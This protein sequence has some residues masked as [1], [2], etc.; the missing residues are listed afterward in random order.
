MRALIVAVVS[1]SSAIAIAAPPKKAAKEAAELAARAD[2]WTVAGRCDEAV[3]D[4]R[5]AVELDPKN[6]LV[7]VRLAHCLA[8]TGGEDEAMKLLD[9]LAAQPGAVGTAALTELGDLAMQKGDFAAAVA[10]YDKLVA[11]SASS[12][13]K[14][15]L[16]DALRSLADKGD[17]AARDRALDLAQKLKNDPK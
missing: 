5:K 1:F 7:A 11:R 8:K 2:A 9:K 4:Y 12:D 17:T 13:A 15:A 10:A 14:T 16:L 3:K 6:G